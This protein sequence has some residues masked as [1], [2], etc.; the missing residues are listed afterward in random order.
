M[1]NT[2]GNCKNL[3]SHDTAMGG[4]FYGCKVTGF[5]VPHHWDSEEAIFWRV[6]VN[7]PRPDSEVVKSETKAPRKDWVTIKQGETGT[8]ALKEPQNEK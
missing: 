4:N 1:E 3:I 5:V 6:P 2:C 7:C 8:P